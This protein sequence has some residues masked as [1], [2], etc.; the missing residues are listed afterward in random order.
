MVGDK[1]VDVSDVVAAA[2]AKMVL[3]RP[4]VRGMIR[5]AAGKGGGSRQNRCCRRECG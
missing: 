2:G 3:D 4:L 1:S 5:Q